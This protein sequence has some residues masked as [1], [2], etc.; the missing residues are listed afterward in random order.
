[1]FFITENSESESLKTLIKNEIEFLIKHEINNYNFN[2]ITIIINNEDEKEISN[3][4]LEIIN[5][6]GQDLLSETF[7]EIE[8]NKLEIQEILGDYF[9]NLI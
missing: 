7:N 4:K 1:M 5:N 8:E 3:K 2:S 6:Y 9:N